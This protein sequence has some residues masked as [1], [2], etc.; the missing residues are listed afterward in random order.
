MHKAIP[1]FSKVD[2]SG[3]DARIV[4]E[5]IN[6]AQKTTFNRTWTLNPKT[7][8]HFLSPMPY[9]CARSHCLKDWDFNDTY[10][11]MLF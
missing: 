10:V 1:G 8:A 7:T 2:H 9:H 5:Q 4:L 3:I 6:S 11:V